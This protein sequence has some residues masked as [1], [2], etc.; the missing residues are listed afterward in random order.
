MFVCMG[1]GKFFS[2]GATNG[3]F[4]TFIHGVPNVVKFVFYHSKLREQLLLLNFQ[5]RGPLLSSMLVC[6]KKFVPHH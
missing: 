3:F 5:I 1:I 2:W 6:R 4:Q